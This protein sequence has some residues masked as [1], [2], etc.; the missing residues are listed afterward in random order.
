L[1]ASIAL[2]ARR[3]ERSSWTDGG[4]P[5]EEKQKDAVKNEL[6]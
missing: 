6:F 4:N 5:A 2:R 1:A 3:A